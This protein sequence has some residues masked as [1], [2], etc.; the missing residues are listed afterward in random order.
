MFGR[1]FRHFALARQGFD[2]SYL[3]TAAIE[4]GRNL[5][6]VGDDGFKVR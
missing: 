1:L 4:Q 6:L 2:G 3:H 5:I